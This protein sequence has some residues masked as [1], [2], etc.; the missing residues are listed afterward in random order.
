MKNIV[1]LLLFTLVILIYVLNLCLK[2]LCVRPTGP[3]GLD[4]SLEGCDDCSAEPF[5]RPLETCD[6]HQQPPEVAEE[7]R[8]L[9]AHSNASFI[10]KH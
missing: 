7:S 1:P 8:Y 4:V 10:C 5:K 3:L 9:Q 6:L 2:G